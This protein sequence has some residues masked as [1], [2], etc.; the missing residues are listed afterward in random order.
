MKPK[1]PKR[2]LVSWPA[3]H[4]KGTTI[5]GIERGRGMCVQAYGS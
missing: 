1:I 4:G 2:G 5:D 3:P